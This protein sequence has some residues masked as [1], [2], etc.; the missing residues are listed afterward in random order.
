MKPSDVQITLN[1]S[2]IAGVSTVVSC[3]IGAV[4]PLPDLYWRIG[5]DVPLT[6]AETVTSNLN[7]DNS[8]TVTAT[9][10]FTFKAENHGQSLHCV[11][12]EKDS[13][14]VVL[15]DEAITLS[16]QCA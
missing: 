9:R 2:I 11:I 14:T 3:V 5:D 13:K 1:E 16:V 6:R 4:K 15:H 8:F 7:A 12:Y 10:T